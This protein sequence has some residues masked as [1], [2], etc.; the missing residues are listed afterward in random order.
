[1]YSAK[2]VE[3]KRLYSMAREGI[4]IERKP[5]LIEIFSIELVSLTEPEP[6]DGV[7]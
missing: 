7:S 4:V 1:M 2:K 3:G 5:S 6:F